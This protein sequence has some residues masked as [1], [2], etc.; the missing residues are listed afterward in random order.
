MSL[1]DIKRCELCGC[2]LEYASDAGAF[3]FTAHTAAFCRSATAARIKVM[4]QMLEETLL[5]ERATYESMIELGKWVSTLTRICSAGRKWI[6]G[7]PNGKMISASDLERSGGEFT[8]SSM[9]NLQMSPAASDL[10]Q[11]LQQAISQVEIQNKRT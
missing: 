9:G 5:R 7:F 10:Y 8:A 6:A 4:Q 2:P 1:D 3:I 11:A